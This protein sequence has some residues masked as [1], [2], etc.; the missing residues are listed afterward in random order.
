MSDIDYMANGRWEG[1]LKKLGIEERF[2]DGKHGPCPICGGKDRFR[3]DDKEGAGTYFCNGCGAGNGYSLLMKT[4][5]WS[6][7]QVAEEI[8][9]IVNGVEVKEK[10][11]RKDPRILLRKI[12]KGA[13][14]LTGDDPASKYLNNR[15]LLLF[16]EELRYHPCLNYYQDGKKIGEYPAMLSPVISQHGKPITYHVTYLTNDGSKADVAAQK[17]IMSS[18]E[19]ISG[20]SVRMFGKGDYICVTEGIETGIAAHESTGLPVMAS[21]NS[22]GMERLSLS[23]DVKGVTIFG[24]ND[25]TY[26]GQKSAYILANKLTVRHNKN[27]NVVISNIEGNDFLDDW[28]SK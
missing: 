10:K 17:K 19:K 7:K 8:K 14:R 4:N 21:I 27:V 11:E 6:F 23:D 1:I 3:F 18:I 25:K 24:D 13:K 9:K 20:A 5:G 22:T 26:T 15:G 28:V 16:P 2:L 12:A